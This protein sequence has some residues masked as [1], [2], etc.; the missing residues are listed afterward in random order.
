MERY[1][2]FETPRLWLRLTSYEDAAFIL[3]LLNSPKWLKYIGDRNVHDLASA[4]VYI[5]KRVQSQYERL[6]FAGYTLI[7]KSD[8]Q[9]LGCCGLYDRE[10]LEG[11][12]LGFALLPQYE[13]QGYGGEAAARLKEAAFAEIGLPSLCAITTKDN[14]ASQS[15]LKKLGFQLDRITRL[16]DDPTPL[17]YLILNAPAP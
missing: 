4:K 5:Q 9:K 14:L 2:E 10:G 11:I 6:G 15:L 13:G 12:D 17:L 8:Q 1:P 16:P 7:R 3:E